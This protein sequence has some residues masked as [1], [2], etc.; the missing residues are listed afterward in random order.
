MRTIASGLT[1]VVLGATLSLAACKTREEQLQAAENDGQ[2]LAAKKSK[3]VE[4]IGKGLQVEGKKA[5][6]SLLKGATGVLKA[7]LKGAEEG[8]FALPVL[9]TEELSQ[10]GLKVERASM[11]KEKGDDGEERYRAVKVYVVFDKPYKGELTLLARDDDDKELGRAKATVD[12]PKA[13][14]KHVVFAFDS[15]VD[16]NLA[17]KVALQ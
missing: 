1:L 6:E 10:A 11:H 14:G 15:L 8:L 13:T 4:G 2:F 9:A 12:E 5:G 16:L 7:G 3:L 17:T